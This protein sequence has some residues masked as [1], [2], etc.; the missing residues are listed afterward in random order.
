[1]RIGH[2]LAGVSL[3]IETQLDAE[4][5][6]WILW[7][8]VAL[9]IGIL[10]YFVLPW[11]PRLSLIM[12]V[13]VA[14]VFFTWLLRQFFLLCL[15]FHFFTLIILGVL[16]M[17][18]KTDFVEAPVLQK[19]LFNVELR[20]FIE[21]RELRPRGRSRLSLRVIQLGHLAPEETPFRVTVSF[22][23]ACDSFACEPGRA[24]ILKAF[25]MPPSGPAVPGGYNFSR[26]S[27]FR[28]L[29][30][31][32]FSTR[33]PMIWE[34]APSPP[35]SLKLRGTLNRLRDIISSRIRA[36]LRDD[37]GAIASALLVGLRGGIPEESLEALRVAGLAH[38]LA[39]SGLHMSLISGCLF[40]FVRAVLAINPFLAE[41]WTI[42]KISA[43]MALLCASTYL[44][45]SGASVSTWRAYTMT[46]IF[47]LGILLDR[48][49]LTMRNV[50]LAALLIMLI[51][52]ESVFSA[53]FQMSF[54]ATA[55]LIAFYESRTV[56]NL[57]RS[58]FMAI[59]AYPLFFR[60]CLFI[61]I[62]L[63]GIIFTTLVASTV[64]APFAAYHFNRVAPFAIIGNVLAMPAVTGLVMPAGLMTF[65]FLPFGLEAI[66][67]F[68]MK[69]G[70]E[71]IL[72]SAEIVS[73]YSGENGRIS[74][75]PDLS[76]F[77]LIIGLLWLVIW[78]S[79]WRFFGIVPL[80]LALCFSFSVQKPDIFI[81]EKVR[82]VAVRDP[83]TGF[84][85]ILS[86]SGS[87]FTVDRWLDFEGDIRDS[88]TMKSKLFRCDKVGCIAP[89]PSGDFIALIRHPSALK[90]DCARAR[91]AIITFRHTMP[92]TGPER[93]ID[94]KD[95]HAYGSRLIWLKKGKIREKNARFKPG[96]RLWR[97]LFS[98]RW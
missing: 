77:L 20:G 31:V 65:L 38:I 26:A 51:N 3:W 8:P 67:L 16:I 52:P 22:R 54:F 39:V 69:L 61:I 12:S 97:P 94:L 32:G 80:I 84:L 87:R 47:F 85:D 28:R 49:A 30:G 68:L 36:V 35:L 34:L 74:Q 4:Q 98:E 40:W 81:D 9:A 70:I 25:L 43:V 78:Q 44:G 71:W 75:M 59:S 73:G 66:P 17:K 42:K 33:P 88:K 91:I 89:L 27:Y 10:I 92:C 13:S 58:S 23:G 19:N 96:V 11:E 86:F 24:V 95:L 57:G 82:A 83:D 55:G 56:R 46:S 79:F 63:L 53:G 64:T 5:Q 15:L 29:G 14:F 45:L 21:K 72:W 48:P 7:S 6:R 90:E 76:F 50:A 18:V 62:S 2:F 1:M 37:T 93:I 41:R 60:S